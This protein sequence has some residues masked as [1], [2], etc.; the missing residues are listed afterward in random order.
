METII[1]IL[2]GVL[3]G[4]GKVIPGVSGSLIAYSLGLYEP[5]IEAISNFFKNLKYNIYFLGRIAIGILIAIIFGSKII[6]YCLTNHYMV[7]MFTFIGLILG[8]F[9]YNSIKFSKKDCFL[10]VGTI[11]ICMF[12]LLQTSNFTYTFQN[13]FIDYIYIFF[14]GFL[15]ALTMIIPGISGTALF[16]ILGCYPFLLLVFQNI[17][18]YLVKNPLLILA[19]SSGLVVGIFITSKLVNYM[20]KKN[21]HIVEVLIL[22]FTISS[23]FYLF[24]KT[25]YTKFFL[26]E[27]LVGLIFLGL[28]YI[29]SY[30]FSS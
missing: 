14:M 18:I 20:F 16:M 17:P 5:C 10:F 15:D 9:R 13:R 29:I 4:I 25:F 11:V 6:A 8:S 24:I 22:S 27:F 21:K 30:L 28:G 19:L 26:L 23:I 7:T 2:K 1:Y 12:I 3:I